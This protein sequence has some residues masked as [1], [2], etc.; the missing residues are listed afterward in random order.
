MNDTDTFKSVSVAALRH[1]HI[2]LAEKAVEDDAY[3]P[4]FAEVDAQLAEYE[5]L[6]GGMRTVDAARRL[7]RMRKTA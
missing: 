5:T 3:L 7:L 6:V 2:A 1:A 4:I